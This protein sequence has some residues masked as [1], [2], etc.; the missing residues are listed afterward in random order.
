MRKRAVRWAPRGA[1]GD[2]EHPIEVYDEVTGLNAVN[3]RCNAKRASKCATCAARHRR[4]VARVGRSGWLDRPTDRGYF[5]TLTAPGEDVLPWDTAQCVHDD[6]VSC[7]GSLG[8]RC[9]VGSLAA[10]HADLGQRWS[11]FVLYLRRELGVDVQYFK[12]FEAQRR[13]AQHAHCMFRFVGE[14]GRRRP[15]GRG[16]RAAW[17]RSRP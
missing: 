3:V 13:G 16:G 10:W 7:S 12:A 8:C 2:C 9:E 15:P 17:R 1:A 5:V 14:C 6:D 11:W 4:N